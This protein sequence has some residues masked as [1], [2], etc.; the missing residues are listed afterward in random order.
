MKRKR[1][2]TGTD[3][4]ELEPDAENR[5]ASIVARATNRPPNHSPSMTPVR[6]SKMIL[7][8]GSF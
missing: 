8:S 1:D 3:K 7:L 6:Q 4:I 5:V 2:K